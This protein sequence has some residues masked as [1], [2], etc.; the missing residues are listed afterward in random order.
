MHPLQVRAF[1]HYISEQTEGAGPVENDGR[2][3]NGVL[4]SVHRVFSNDVSIRPQ[5]I[6]HGELGL[7]RIRQDQDP[8]S[9]REQHSTAAQACGPNAAAVSRDNVSSGTIDPI[10]WRHLKYSA[11]WTARVTQLL[12]FLAGRLRKES[13]ATENRQV[14]EE[15]SLVR[16]R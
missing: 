2:F 4:K 14:A 16:P 6:E 12:W 3:G 1:A 9:H 11:S 13:N 10:N 8:G 15:L 5:F 7:A